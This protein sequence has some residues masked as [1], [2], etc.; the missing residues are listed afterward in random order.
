VSADQTTDVTAPVELAP[1]ELTLRDGRQVTVP[2]E[3]TETPQ[4]WITP[5]VDLHDGRWS[6][7]W[8]LT[9][10]PTGL[11]LLTS[12]R[13]SF[14]RDVAAELRSLDW[15]FTS[16]DTAPAATEEAAK[17]V[18]SL[19]IVDAYRYDEDDWTGEL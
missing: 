5:T 16:R 6:G 12:D 15:A 10:E 11:Y 14:L 2:G 9:H 19:A 13:P 8:S 18:L 17:K 7:N 4:L 3:P 1:I